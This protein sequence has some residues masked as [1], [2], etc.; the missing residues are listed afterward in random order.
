MPTQTHNGWKMAQHSVRTLL[1][2]ILLVGC[3]VT[4]RNP[5]TIRVAEAEAV[6]T[7][8]EH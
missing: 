5:S 4:T 6:L 8:A 1:A 2:V 3:G 7:R